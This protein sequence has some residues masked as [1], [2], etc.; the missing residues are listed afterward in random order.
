MDPVKHSIDLLHEMSLIL[1]TGLDKETL[2]LCVSLIESGV[3]PEA[4]VSVIKELQRE[5]QALRS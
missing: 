3:N 2:C 4:L 5:A 1:N